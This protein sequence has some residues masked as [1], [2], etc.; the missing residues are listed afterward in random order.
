MQDRDAADA[1]DEAEKRPEQEDQLGLRIGGR[2]RPQGRADDAG[3]RI[4]ELEVGDYARGDRLVGGF[5]LG[6][7]QGDPALQELAA[8]LIRGGADEH[9]VADIGGRDRVRQA[10]G[11]LRRQPP[12][13]HFENVG[14]PEPLDLDPVGEVLEG[15]FAGAHRLLL[16]RE[17]RRGQEGKQA[18]DPGEGPADEARSFGRVGRILVETE[19]V[20]HVA[21]VARRADDLHLAFRLGAVEGRS[22]GGGGRRRVG[23]RRQA[24]PRFERDLGRRH[25]FGLGDQ[26]VGDAGGRTEQN[27][28]REGQSLPPDGRDQ[29][30]DK[31]RLGI[32]P[33]RARIRR[34]EPGT[35]AVMR[36]VRADDHG[37][38]VH[39]EAARSGVRRRRSRSSAAMR[40]PTRRPRRST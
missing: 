7:D 6:L 25:E 38:V 40:F 1:A 19:G 20:E 37:A 36:I 26:H 17:G 13:G 5:L 29:V 11:I 4:R 8:A 9:L 12:E 32:V 34:F 30:A 22:R 24:H 16:R 14:L 33:E 3:I 10:G 23:A 28:Q 39:R 35:R 21:Q 18:R 15:D 27:P 2:E 31:R